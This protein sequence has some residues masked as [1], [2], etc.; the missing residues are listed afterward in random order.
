MW[1]FTSPAFIGSSEARTQ[2]G[3]LLSSALQG[4]DENSVAKA[5]EDSIKALQ[6]IK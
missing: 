4:K 2:V 6:S 3:A 1:F 5:F